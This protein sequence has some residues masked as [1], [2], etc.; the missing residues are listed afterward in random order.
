MQT[1]HYNDTVRESLA[2]ARRPLCTVMEEEYGDIP[3]A[4]FRRAPW[5]KDRAARQLEVDDDHRCAPHED[6]C[7]FVD[8]LPPHTPLEPD[9]DAFQ[10]QQVRATARTPQP[11][12]ELTP[13]ECSRSMRKHRPRTHCGVCTTNMSHCRGRYSNTTLNRRRPRHS[14][15]TLSNCQKSSRHRRRP[16]AIALRRRRTSNT[17]ISR[18]RRRPPVIALAAPVHHHRRHPR[19]RHAA[20]LRCTA[21]PHVMLVTGCRASGWARIARHLMPRRWMDSSCWRSPT[22]S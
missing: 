19:P 16:P 10:E 3:E 2:N 17:T 7:E 8:A 18:R 1:A 15:I 14:A 4:G 22:N 11:L 5:L 9:V 21:G 6:E 13:D 12:S 20:R